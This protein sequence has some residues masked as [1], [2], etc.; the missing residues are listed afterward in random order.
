M[1]ATVCD[2]RSKMGA[3]QGMY[4]PIIEI[5]T[6]R[7]DRIELSARYSRSGAYK[8][9]VALIYLLP[10]IYTPCISSL[11]AHVRTPC[12]TRLYVILTTAVLL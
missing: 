10:Y 4:S 9:Y 7:L 1:T 6:A 3:Q 8:L 5:R 12:I 11:L 2:G